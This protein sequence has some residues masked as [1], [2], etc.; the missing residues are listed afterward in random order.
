MQAV[1]DEVSRVVPDASRREKIHATVDRYEDELRTFDRYVSEFKDRLQVLSSNPDVSRAQFTDQI[2]QYEGERKA[3][4][5]RLV[6]IH[7]ELLALTTDSEWR[8]LAKREIQVLR[9]ADPGRARQEAK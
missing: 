5:A 1:R 2:A 6:Q 3:T 4:R 8:S 7:H 9:L